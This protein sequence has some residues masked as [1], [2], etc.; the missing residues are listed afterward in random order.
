MFKALRRS[1]LKESIYFTCTIGSASKKTHAQWHVSSP[2]DVIKLMSELVMLSN[3]V[4]RPK[5]VG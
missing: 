5:P 4:L 1:D 2:D 3:T